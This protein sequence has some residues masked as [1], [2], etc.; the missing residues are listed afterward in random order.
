[1]NFGQELFVDFFFGAAFFAS[2]VFLAGAFFPV[3][4]FLG[5]A[6]FAGS[7]LGAASFFG[8]SFL[9]AVFLGAVTFF[10]GFGATTLALLIKKSSALLRIKRDIAMAFYS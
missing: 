7:F 5:A 10:F 3:A 9:S 2:V 6:F 1:M 8:V 4:V